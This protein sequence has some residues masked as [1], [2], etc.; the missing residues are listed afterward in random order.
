MEQKVRFDWKGVISSGYSFIKSLF[1]IAPS[2]S[3][4]WKLL[5]Q[6]YC[7]IFRSSHLFPWGWDKA[8]S[9]C[10]V[11]LF[12]MLYCRYNCEPLSCLLY[13]HLYFPVYYC[14]YTVLSR[15]PALKVLFFGFE[16]SIDITKKTSSSNHIHKNFYQNRNNE[17]CIT[18]KWDR[19]G[20]LVQPQQ[21][22]FFFSLKFV[23]N[24]DKMKV[25]FKSL[26]FHSCLVHVWAM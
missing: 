4:E 5:P 15:A 9:C 1:L 18:W 26:I 6:V 23:T 17:L 14:K 20:Y 7:C 3:E 12:K 2:T 25:N 8:S 19:R 24:L 22:F 11:A 21:I 10:A 13:L 16:Y